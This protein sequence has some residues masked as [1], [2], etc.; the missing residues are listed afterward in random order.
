MAQEAFQV[1][2]ASPAF[3]D[4]HLKHAAMKSHL[5][6]IRF[7]CVCALCIGA[8]IVSAEAQSIRDIPIAELIGK[9]T[10]GD[11]RSQYLLGLAYSLGINVPKDARQ[12]VIWYE[13]AAVQGNA[14]AITAMGQSLEY[15]LG[16]P[17]DVS[18]AIEWYEKIAPTAEDATGAA[19]RSHYALARLSRAGQT[20]TKYG[21]TPGP[22]W[23]SGFWILDDTTPT[24][25]LVQQLAEHTELE[26]T[27][28]GYSIGY[29][30][31][32]LSIAA[33][34]DEALPLLENFVRNAK[35]LQERRAGL[36]TI[37]LIGIESNAIGGYDEN[38]QNRRARETL[39][40]L[41]KIEGLTDMV[42]RLLKRDPWPADIPAIMEAVSVVKEDCVATLNS[43]R[44][45][46]MPECPLDTAPK[47]EAEHDIGFHYYWSG[48]DVS[49][50]IEGL[51]HVFPYEVVI[52]P[53][54]QPEIREAKRDP[55][56]RQEY[57]KG[58]LKELMDVIKD[59]HAPSDFVLDGSPLFF[60]FE[61]KEESFEPSTTVRF[62]GPAS[63]RVVLLKWWSEK[64][65]QRYCYTLPDAKAPAR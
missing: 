41:M 31:H 37:H 59:L 34:K 35:S 58:T 38:F 36:F 9:A 32:M 57:W 26:S 61:K 45:Y 46:A 8:L 15:G 54:V 49:N 10:A 11:S 27:E 13:K 6:R 48:L 30:Q 14:N 17:K 29:N 24:E 28:K 18:K 60:T 39:W 25:K 55:G 43:L 42:S 22:M 64:G 1:N 52:G 19:A 62:F 12:A 63:A 50:A 65:R 7:A 3:N 56:M 16:I 4:C 33:R 5:L 44:R 2:G 21:I 20:K 47:Y 40:R 51:R 23:G 53:D